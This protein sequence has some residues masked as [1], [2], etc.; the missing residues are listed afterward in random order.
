MSY[1]KH[2]WDFL[3]KIKRLGK[4]PEVAI[5]VTADV[6][7]HYPNVPHNLGVQL[8]RKRL[9]ETCTCKLPTEEIVSMA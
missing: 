9:D 5:L 3:K 2:T 1:V 7:G 6:A 8:L 4:I